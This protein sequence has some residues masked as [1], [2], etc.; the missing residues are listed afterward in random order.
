MTTPSFAALTAF[1]EAGQAQSRD[2]WSVALSLLDRAIELD[3]GFAMAQASLG[4]LQ[5]RLNRIPDALRWLREADSRVTRL[6]EPEQLLVKA[7]LAR[8]EG[9]TQDF[10]S[11]AGAF[12]TRFPSAAGWVLYSE[13]LRANGAPGEAAAA[14]HRGIELD[15]A[16]LFAWHGLALA[17]RMQGNYRQALDAYAEI[18][19]RDSTWLQSTFVNQQWGATFV[20][21]GAF[22]SAAA[23]FRRMLRLPSPLDQARGH[24][25]L[26]Y[27]AMY[28]GQYAL[29]RDEIRQAIQLQ[30]R[31][32]LSEYRD[33]VLLADLSRTQDDRVTA[34]A[35]LDRAYEIARGS[36]LEAAALMFAGHQSVLSRDLPRARSY[37]AAATKIAALRPDSRQDQESLAI[38]EGDLALA[39]GRLQAA[40]EV[41]GRSDFRVYPTLGRLLRAEAF[42]GLGQIDSAL[43][44]ARAAN[45]AP[46]F[47]LEVQ[48]DWLRSFGTVARI[49]EAAGDVATARET[50]SALLEL[51]QQ[52][53]S[54]LPPLLE[55]RRELARLQTAAGR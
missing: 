37:V 31:G 11:Q 46:Q 5:L 14:A 30:T 9:R 24:R 34:A 17:E 43:A 50:W 41:L 53:D 42:F 2:E 32:S 4:D 1:A 12:A 22:D 19:R 13:A 16:N 51:W 27:L 7:R 35:A 39:E 38:L 20:M 36:Q 25:A 55:A 21:V 8:A 40:R 3:T 23:V 33:V 10:L 48:G 47:G 18:D 44:L 52:A 29:A 49:A 54:T 45:A 15:T 6:T 28:R 26:A